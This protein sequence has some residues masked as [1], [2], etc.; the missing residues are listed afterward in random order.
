[1]SKLSELEEAVKIANAILDGGCGHSLYITSGPHADAD[2]DIHILARQFHRLMESA[3]VKSD[4]PEMPVRPRGANADEWHLFLCEY[5]DSRA[6]YP[7]GLEFVAV[8]ISEAIEAER[9]RCANIV[10]AHLG[11][12]IYQVGICIKAIE[13]G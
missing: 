8:Q 1:M 6:T 9:D 7:G 3:R 4:T 13:N 5:M 10:R 12:D 11:G 2:D